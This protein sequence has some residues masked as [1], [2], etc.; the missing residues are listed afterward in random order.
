MY[1]A[2]GLNTLLNTDEHSTEILSV[3]C[4]AFRPVCVSELFSLIFYKYMVVKYPVGIWF[5][6]QILVKMIPYVSPENKTNW[7][8]RLVVSGVQVSLQ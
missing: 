7:V 4:Q 5:Y 1:Y 6:L 3:C 2:R 8:C